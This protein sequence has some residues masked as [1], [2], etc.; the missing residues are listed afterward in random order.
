[1]PIELDSEIV[2]PGDVLAIDYA[3]AADNATLERWAIRRTKEEVARAS[4][5]RLSVEQDA[6]GVQHADREERHHASHL[7]QSPRNREGHTNASPRGECWQN[8]SN[9][10]NYCS[11]GRFDGDI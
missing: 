5:A 7:G 1:M 6:I 9:L 8:H 11:D 3:I 2:R 4:D 10:Y